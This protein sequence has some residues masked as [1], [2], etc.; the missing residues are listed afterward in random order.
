LS[1]I[2]NCGVRKKYKPNKRIR[3]E[4]GMN[5]PEDGSGTPHAGSPLP[6]PLPGSFG[7]F[8][9]TSAP[10]EVDALVARVG[11]P[12]DGAVVTFVGIVRDNQDGRG[13]TALE[14]E[15]YAEMAEA[16]MRALSLQVATEYGLHG[17]AIQHRVGRLGIGEISVVI[18]VAAAH[19]E[20]AFLG[21]AAALERLKTQVP[22]WKK[23]YY[24]DG[25]VWL[26]LVGG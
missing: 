12:A 11:T 2:G 5:L 16:E 7:P 9:I 6:D 4:V 13:V 18:A 1:A 14:Y 10:L 20:A 26:G 24:V 23:E 25:A 21:C 3:V 19:R 17:I 8:A 22:V 15:A